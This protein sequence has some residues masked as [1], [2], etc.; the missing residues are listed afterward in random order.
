MEL[1]PF[2][3]NDSIYKDEMP[4]DGFSNEELVLY[5]KRLMDMGYKER[6][7]RVVDEGLKRMQKG[8]SHRLLSALRF[9]KDLPKVAQV[10]RHL[11]CFQC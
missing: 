7:L 8:L 3:S 2:A 4:L 11:P 5:C 9:R 10:L 1:S 6:A